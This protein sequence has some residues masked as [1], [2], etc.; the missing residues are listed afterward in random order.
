MGAKHVHTQT[1]K[2]FFIWSEGSWLAALP[3]NEIV[4]LLI[5]TIRYEMSPND[6][7]VTWYREVFMH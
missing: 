5:T 1:S 3:K 2:S 4:F 6:R 7:F